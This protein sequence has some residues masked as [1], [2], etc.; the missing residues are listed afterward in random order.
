MIDASP[1]AA[2]AKPLR[3]RV[4]IA[5]TALGALLSLSFAAAAVFIAEDY[6]A[7]L[8]DEILGSQAQDY[9][10]ALAAD[11]RASLPRS[12]RLSGYLRRSDGSGDVP[13]A[14]RALAPGVHDDEDG[15]PADMTVGVY[16]IGQGRLYFVMDAS[17]IEMME[18]HLA[19]FLVAIVLTGTAL[20]AWLG[21]FLAGVSLAPLRRL[22]ASVDALPTRPQPTRLA[23][24]TGA[25]ELGRLAH[26]IDEYQARLVDA[27]AEERR[28]FADAS[29]ELRTPL[30]VIRGAAEL[31]LD[32]TASPD[33][34]RTWRARFERGMDELTLLLEV[35][36]GLGR[37]DALVPEQETFEN[38]VHAAIVA[39]GLDGRFVVTIEQS[40]H[41]WRVPRR[42]A[43]LL[44]QDLLRR[45]ASGVPAG[46][47]WAHATPGELVFTLVPSSDIDAASSGGAARRGLA[48]A[49]GE[50]AS[51]RTLVARLAQRMGWRIAL[52]EESDGV[53]IA[54]VGFD[55]ANS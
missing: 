39:A 1:V 7:I 16:D 10:L 42:E 30:A 23:Q 32:E 43:G 12:H 27:D 6:E 49:R 55:A 8:I 41:A 2:R 37:G 47:L 3:W 33:D 19:W 5:T 15:L 50:S 9:G 25:D 18:L 21:W 13:P 52:R 45:L 54:Q 20:A 34:Q 4:T 17:D 53:R 38:L 24:A 14:L 40:L 46:A 22:A 26:A 36:L 11:P 28:F 29:H 48:W 51:G 31:M 35:L 44:L